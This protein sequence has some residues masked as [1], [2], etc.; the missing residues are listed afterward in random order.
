[1]GRHDGK[2]EKDLCNLGSPFPDSF[3][4]S[5]APITLDTKFLYDQFRE[6]LPGALVSSLFFQ[7][8]YAW[9]FTLSQRYK[10]IGGHLCILTGDSI[11]REIYA[12]P[13]LGVLGTL[14]FDGALDFLYSAFEGEGL[15]LTFN[16]VP[17]YMLRFFLSLK[18]YDANVS[19]SVDWSDYSFLREDFMNGIN[20]S[21]SREAMR[22][23]ER[24]GRS[25]VREITP[26]D[27]NRVLAVTR[28]YFCGKRVCAD[29]FC[30]CEAVV[31]S[32]A[33]GAF[34]ELGLAGVIV[35]SEGAPIAFCLGCSQK[36]TFLFFL[37]KVKHS[38]RGLNEYIN[39]QMMERFGGNVKY[40]NYSEDMG[41]AGLR[42]YKSR[43]GRYTLMHRHTVE[44][45]R[46]E[47]SW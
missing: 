23:F 35:E 41:N 45:R 39:V 14:S 6:P 3:L 42:L 24:N 26:S 37:K 9:N 47:I 22:H 46:R 43:L 7:S 16:E 31:V 34:R 2:W 8:L 20:K 5:F 4:R 44:L 19:F 21:S 18:N 38:V 17:E 33:M 36:D 27:I 1:L 13:P 12:L 28:N 32:R 25:V 15:S 30:G 11:T 29:C 10:V 40:V